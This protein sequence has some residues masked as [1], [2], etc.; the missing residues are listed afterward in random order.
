MK[1]FIN[2]YYIIYGIIIITFFVLIIIA[3]KGFTGP[4]FYG[5]LSH[6]CINLDDGWYLEDGTKADINH[7]NKNSGAGANKQFSVFHKLPEEID[8]NVSL[9]FRSKNSPFKLY[10]DGELRYEP[11]VT[12]NP[13]YTKSYGS[14]WHLVELSPSDSGKTLELKTTTVYEKKRSSYD[15][16][17]IDSGAGLVLSNISDQLAAIITSILL[18]FS[19]IILVV[20]DIPINRIQKK[21]HELL[22]LGMFAM[23]IALWCLAETNVLQLFTGNFPAIQLISYLSLMLIPIPGA[24]YINEIYKPKRLF[25]VY[26]TLI[27][28]SAEFFICL[29]L[30]LLKILDYRETLI[31]T[32]IMLAFT[33]ITLTTGIAKKL[34]ELI[35]SKTNIIYVLLR[36]VGLSSLCLGAAADIIRFYRSSSVDTAL[37]TRSAILVFIS[38][39]GA[40]SLQQTVEAVKAGARAKFISQLAY[41]DGLTGI[42]NRTAFQE[43]LSELEEK[44]NDASE[45]GIIMFDVNDLK[46]V[47]DNMGHHLGDKMLLSSAEIIR[48]SFE[49]KNSRCFRIGGDEFVVIMNGENIRNRCESALTNFNSEIIRFN[50]LKEFPFSISIASGFSIYGETRDN[51]NPGLSLADI[52]KEADLLMYENKKKMKSLT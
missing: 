50:R 47:N 39:Y 14:A 15:S 51:E 43:H 20:A 8:S 36:S 6:G 26:L 10:I 32:H 5:R 21:T 9:L 23:S 11:Y 22:F 35:K 27:G 49:N 45:I 19:G 1:N 16:F 13:A 40:S 34:I 25:I 7:L 38:C 17:R 33:V 52:L 48:S 4:S 31:A 30:N 29:I 12:D 41:I 44:K 24:L 42:G 46:K 18:F 2:K 3:F 28:S 37:F